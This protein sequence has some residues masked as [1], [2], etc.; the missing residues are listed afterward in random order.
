MKKCLAIFG[1]ALVSM[2][3]TGCA[4]ITES[5]AERAHNF[6]QVENYNA[7]MFNEDFDDFWL[8]DRPSRLSTWIVR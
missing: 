5:P 3:M 7:M 1:L 6:R 8:I 4:T 2:V